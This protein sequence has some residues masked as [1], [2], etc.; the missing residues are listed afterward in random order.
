MQSSLANLSQYETRCACKSIGVLLVA[1]LIIALS[2]AEHLHESLPHTQ[3]HA[4]WDKR[5]SVA[6]M[7]QQRTLRASCCRLG[8]N[9]R[10]CLDPMMYCGCASPL[11]GSTVIGQQ[12]YV[13]DGDAEGSA[14]LDIVRFHP[15]V[16]ALPSDDAAAFAM[17]GASAR[18]CLSCN[19]SPPG[20]LH[21]MPQPAS[22]LHRIAIGASGGA[23][24]R[25]SAY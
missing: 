23:V 18:Y 15:P 6:G 20:L 16:F 2:I 22:R 13:L 11:E 14:L 17:A 9:R 10:R 3:W 12:L 5:S 24:R 4:V 8:S 25:S 21:G 7:V 1:L 19:L